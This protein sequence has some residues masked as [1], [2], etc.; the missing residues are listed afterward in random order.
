[1][2]RWRRATRRCTATK[3]W[4]ATPLPRWITR[5]NIQ[6]GAEQRALRIKLI[7]KG[8]IA[9]LITVARNPPR[10][11]LLNRE[12]LTA[13]VDVAMASRNQALYGYERVV[14]NAFASR[15]DA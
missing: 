13:Q 5:W 10:L 8:R 3:G 1:M 9:I 7:E 14:R 2:W 4:C 12:A 11:P 15:K 6:L